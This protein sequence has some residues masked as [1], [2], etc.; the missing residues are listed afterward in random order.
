[1]DTVSLK[2]KINSIM[3]SGI[4][5]G[6]SVFA[7]LE[8]DTQPRLKQ[9]LID[10]NLRSQLIQMLDREVKDRFLADEV[11]VDSSENIADK[12]RV[13]YEFQQSETHAPFRI[14]SQWDY[15]TEQ[16]S[17]SD[18]KKLRGLLFRI[19]RNDDDIWVYQRVYNVSLVKRSKSL[20]AA[21]GKT[22][23]YVLMDSDVLRIDSRIDV[24]VVGDSFFSSNI[25]LLQK[26]FGFD[27]YIRGEAAK[28]IQLIDE[29]DIVSDTGKITAF[30]D[31]E[32]L[33]NAKK[34][35]QAKSSPVLKM[36]KRDLLTR[37][38]KHPRYKDKFKIQNDKIVITSQKDAGE[39]IKL[40]ND[41]ILR[42]EL[43]GREYDSLSK[44]ILD[45]LKVGAG[46]S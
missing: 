11:E 8:D 22:N 43:T 36:K 28:T 39:F 24:L 16:Y 20:L 15:V 34:L 5:H 2:S 35:L 19:N 38:K 7:W 18:Q 13:L 17:E 27:R 4:N 25:D 31:K 9:F 46:A 26:S 23:T 44:K 45:P 21:V 6:L 12:R 41:D 37:I 42:S 30:G 32:T 29:L 1:M 10:E 14:I 40:L 3:F 33:S